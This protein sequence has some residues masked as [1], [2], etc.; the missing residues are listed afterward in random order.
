MSDWLTGGSHADDIAAYQA[1]IDAVPEAERVTPEA[2]R[3]CALDHIR[4]YVERGDLYEWL[5]E[6]CGG[7]Y[8]PHYHAQ[9]GSMGKYGCPR[10]RFGA[11]TLSIG[12]VNRVPC[13]FQFSLRELYDEIKSGTKQL[14]MFAQAVTP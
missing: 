13:C 12:E 8:S 6:S 3:A 11:D 4:R 10:P 14:S 1:R 9:I 7:S 2:A 5:K